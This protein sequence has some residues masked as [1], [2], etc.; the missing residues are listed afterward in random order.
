[1]KNSYEIFALQ[2]K[3]L[4]HSMGGAISFMYAAF[5][6]EEVEFVISLDAAS[7]CVK[8]IKTYV[9]E[10]RDLIDKFIKNDDPN[11]NY[12]ISCYEYDEIVE[13]YQQVYKDSV[14]RESAETL[15][16]RGMRPALQNPGKFYLS[17]DPRLNV[18]KFFFYRIFNCFFFGNN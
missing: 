8:E 1:M 15:L 6:P 16:K 13:K 4:G 14:D 17:R 12:K 11:I 3:L 10:T 2:I 5:Y 9:A 7:P 18:N